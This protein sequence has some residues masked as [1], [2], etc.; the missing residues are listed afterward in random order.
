[1]GQNHQ[2]LHITLQTVHIFIQYFNELINGEMIVKSTSAA[3][4]HLINQSDSCQMPG[5]V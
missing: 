3:A 4:L 1:M 5:R 2:F